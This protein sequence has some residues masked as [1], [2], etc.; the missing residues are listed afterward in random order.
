MHFLF[1][2]KV[3]KISR[4]R[5]VAGLEISTRFVLFASRNLEMSRR[6]FEDSFSAVSKS[7]FVSKY[8]LESSWRDLQDLHA[9]TPFDSNLET[10]H[11]SEFENSAKLVFAFCGFITFIFKNSPIVYRFLSKIH[12]RLWTISGISAMC[13]ETFSFLRFRNEN[14]WFFRKYFSET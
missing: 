13:T 14:C 7:I 1:V 3:T 4:G 5:Y 8:S 2:K 12:Q 11:R 10:M 6:T 9:F